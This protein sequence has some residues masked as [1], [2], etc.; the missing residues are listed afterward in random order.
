MPHHCQGRRFL[1]N[2]SRSCDLHIDPTPTQ[3]TTGS[4]VVFSQN[5][6]LNYLE[7]QGFDRLQTPVWIL[8]IDRQPVWWANRAALWL[9]EVGTIEELRQQD[10]RDGW[11]PHRETSI[12]TLEQLELG[13]TAVGTWKISRTG[14]S[15]SLTCTCSGIELEDGQLAILVESVGSYLSL[16]SGDRGLPYSAIP[17]LVTSRGDRSSDDF[18]PDTPAQYPSLEG[19]IEAINQLLAHRKHQEGINRA[20]EVL[21]AATEVDRIYIWEN[22]F[23]PTTAEVLLSQRAQWQIDGVTDR[24]HAQ[25]QGLSYREFLPNW[26][27]SLA[28]GQPIVGTVRDFP[29]CERDL[30]APWGIRSMLLVPIEIDG[31]FWGCIGFDE[32]DRPRSDSTPHRS[33]QS[34]DLDWFDRARS[35]LASPIRRLG[36]IVA[37]LLAQAEFEMRDRLLEG[38]AWS[39]N[40]LLTKTDR[41]WALDRA[42]KMLGYAAG[43]DRVCV[44][45]YH[46]HPST[47]ERL[48]T[49]QWQWSSEELESPMELSKWYQSFSLDE[50]ICGLARDF[51]D[52]V[53]ALLDQ[54]GIRSLLALPV[55]VEGQLWGCLEFDNYHHDRLWSETEKLI[56]RAAAGSVGGAIARRYTEAKLKERDRLLDGVATATTQ[57]LTT[58]DDRASIHQA[59]SALGYAAS[60]DRVYI[61][62]RHLDSISGNALVS[63]RYEWMAQSTEV[64][65]EGLQNIPCDGVFARWFERLSTGQLVCGLVRD[66]P[67][68]ERQFLQTP[69]VRS[70]ALVPIESEGECWGFLGFDECG[71]ERQ[72][73]ESEKSI[74][75]AAAGSIGGAIAR[76]KTATQLAR[77]NAQL[78]RRVQE[79]TA[80]L[81]MVNRQLNYN[82]Y[83]DA[84]TGLPNRVLL[85]EELE[86]ALAQV[87]EQPAYSFAIL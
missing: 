6:V 82:T 56:L 47:G 83:H 68:A 62:E 23:H 42:L 81:M 10:V 13:K 38:V 30:F 64:A 8:K 85:M 7:V 72:W 15:I 11:H 70:F 57:L 2:P 59:L 78:E 12:E 22:H 40:L 1:G 79:R 77:L 25:L 29:T 63:Q 34:R 21:G 27:E 43:V 52:E 84:L 51:D 60:V 87:G 16:D 18:A 31:H 86:K 49:P 65:I 73:S 76:Q 46:P 61:L 17:H 35:I 32:C 53:R 50:A 20:L 14:G 39:T 26:Y 80:E 4:S 66:L 44:L 33:S 9:W 24:L 55:E 54:Q 28:G 48:A 74:L 71:G 45:K 5:L 69:N 3:E 36:E 41:D 67:E 75:K 58:H 19:I 37:R